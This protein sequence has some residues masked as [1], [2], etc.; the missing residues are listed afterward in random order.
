[1]LNNMRSALKTEVVHWKF[2][3]MLEAVC[4]VE[5]TAMDVE[6]TNEVVSLILGQISGL[7]RKSDAH[8]HRKGRR[9]GHVRPNR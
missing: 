8:L 1:M 6:A 3:I 7:S 4:R 9:S 2:E 5:Q